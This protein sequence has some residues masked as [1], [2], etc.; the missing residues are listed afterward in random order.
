MLYVRNVR[1]GEYAFRRNKFERYRW[2]Q[3]LLAGNVLLQ[4]NES[5]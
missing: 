4:I 5:R 2:K 3:Q 1:S